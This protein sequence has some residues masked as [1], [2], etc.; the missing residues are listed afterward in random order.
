MAIKVID[1]NDHIRA[2]F[3][4]IQSQGDPSTIS[5]NH[6]DLIIY[7]DIRARR[8]A[9]SFISK[10]SQTVDTFNQGSN[11]VIYMF[12]F[13]REKNLLTTNWTE[14]VSSNKKITKDDNVDFE[15]FGMTDIV[16]KFESQYMPRVNITFIDIRG[17]SLME[18]GNKS[19]YELF[20]NMPYP[21]FELTVKGYY[22]KPVTYCLHLLKFN[23]K[24]DAATGHFEITTEFIGSTFAFLTDILMG[25]AIT[26]PY[27][28][29]SANSPEVETIYSL[30]EKAEKI[31]ELINK[32][33]PDSFE[34]REK[35]N[36]EE[37]VDYFDDIQRSFDGFIENFDANKYVNSVLTITDEQWHP[38]LSPPNE[39]S[40]TQNVEQPNLNPKTGFEKKYDEF[41]LKVD[42]DIR[43]MN[44][45]KSNSITLSYPNTNGN[46]I[47]FNEFLKE[48]NNFKTINDTNLNDAK[49]KLTNLINKKS[50]L[51]LGF[52]P[53]IGNIFKVMLGDAEKFLNLLRDCSGDAQ[54]ITDNGNGKGKYVDST[55]SDS[56][57]DKNLIYP[58]PSYYTTSTETDENQNRIS[59]TEF[60]Y[61]EE[62]RKPN[63][64]FY[65]DW[66]EVAFVNKFID[67]YADLNQTSELVTTSAGW[68]PINI[69]ESTLIS[70]TRRSPYRDIL[71]SNN[72][73][74]NGLAYRIFTRALISCNYTHNIE[75]QSSNT[76]G[77]IR[78]MDESIDVLAELEANNFFYTKRDDTDDKLLKILCNSQPL[79]LISQAVNHSVTLT[80]GTITTTSS[81]FLVANG[82]TDD[83]YIIQDK[84]LINKVG[85]SID[86]STSDYKILIE[87]FNIVN[88]GAEDVQQSILEKI[89]TLYSPKVSGWA[90]I[91]KWIFG[92]DELSDD[93]VNKEYSDKD[94]TVFLDTKHHVLRFSNTYDFDQYRLN[95]S[96]KGSK[97]SDHF[98]YEI[99]NHTSGLLNETDVKNDGYKYIGLVTGLSLENI[100]KRREIFSFN[101]NLFKHKNSEQ[102]V[103]NDFF[104]T[105][106]FNNQSN[107]GKA[108]LLLNY[109]RFKP[110]K[111]YKFKFT[112]TGGVVEVPYLWVLWMGSIFYREREINLGNN[113]VLSPDILEVET[114]KLHRGRGSDPIIK[115]YPVA[116]PNNTSLFRLGDGDTMFFSDDANDYVNWND[117]NND[118][119]GELRLISDDN[120][121]V[122]I[123]EF[124]S[125]V[126]SD[127]DSSFSELYTEMLELQPY[128]PSILNFNVVSKNSDNIGFIQNGV[129]R[130][131]YGYFYLLDNDLNAHGLQSLNN[132][133]N[134]RKVILNPTYKTW[135][136]DSGGNV[137]GNPLVI[138]LTKTRTE[139]YFNKF[140]RTLKDLVLREEKDDDVDDGST[141]QITNNDIR[142]VTY[143]S[144]KSIYD[145]WVGGTNDHIYKM[146]GDFGDSKLS[147]MF[148]FVDRAFNDIKDT[149]YLDVTIFK[150]LREQPDMSLYDFIGYILA[151]SDFDFHALPSFIAPERGK[152]NAGDLYDKYLFAP[153]TRVDRD[154]A[155]SFPAFICMYIGKYSSHLDIEGS[156]YPSD[157]FD[158]DIAAPGDY[159]NNGNMLRGF[160]VNF[161]E[162]N[163]NVFKTI[164][165]NQEEFKETNESLKAVDE[166][167]SNKDTNKLSF[168]SGN[169]YN[170]YLTR[171]YTCTVESLGNM[172]I[173]PL[174]Y[175]QLN[176]VPMFHGAYLITSV[177][178]QFKP[179]YAQTTFVGSRVP[180]ANIPIPDNFA[181][182]TKTGE[183]KEDVVI[184]KNDQDW[185]G[186]LITLGI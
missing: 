5:V 115:T 110:Y 84:V 134:E 184:T 83:V 153:S 169:L 180:I 79:D 2:A 119:Y 75:K 176:N 160:A 24:Y 19:K 31:D 88:E 117:Q 73:A 98:Y 141:S 39:I 108:Y 93:E 71:S 99:V 123:N 155:A 120:K 63:T 38:P 161:G 23:S 86:K 104:Y 182:A 128:S 47:D 179:H 178:H 137:G 136:S 10:N 158:L 27:L 100:D 41:K 25:Y 165:L 66:P 8:R 183:K 49:E 16:I 42:T 56:K 138:Y 7:A 61:P 124:L 129:F 131:R 35:S 151:D 44:K 118:Q 156:D 9:R 167:T 53:T 76:E 125:W 13:N 57:R 127:S 81:P 171:S 29:G 106:F 64:S 55:T 50:E 145:K 185:R 94:K 34:N 126:R 3:N 21:I 91:K 58:W 70:T 80:A 135:V 101:S 159:T 143:L 132:L 105:S 32:E 112:V 162:Q 168:Y 51:V 69:N 20:F 144:F 139:K 59:R 157:G 113:D 77:R 154:S 60:K 163:Q 6:E 40:S 142:L 133:L 130:N 146:C 72:D 111:F 4:G 28:D 15:T 147:D 68:F 62:L 22:G 107:F 90:N 67:T 26:A 87:D 173:Q 122:L 114:Q 95:I 97:K 52:K 82:Q 170:V 45:I 172:M 48:L 174:M 18:P 17:Q 11:D 175:F 177:T 164:Q 14:Y 78:S 103:I 46:T 186:Q 149:T 37:L 92:D 54:S 30:I 12:G 33:I 85:Q 152:L 109:L 43:I 116:L 102:G 1:P 140:I 150:Q 36:Y 74:L 148:Y 65:S 181:L 89:N 121:Q 96:D 166:L